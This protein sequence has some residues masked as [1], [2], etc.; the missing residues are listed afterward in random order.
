M[1]VQ[2]TD[3]ALIASNLISGKLEIVWRVSASKAYYSAF[4]RAPK[5]VDICPDNSKLA[6]G[7]HER[8]SNRFWL[9][10]DVKVRSVSYALNTMKKIRHIADYDLDDKF[11]KNTAVKQISDLQVFCEQ[12][13]KI[14]AKFRL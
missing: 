14:D 11:H 1:S 3:F 12:V 13:D 9:H 2:Y 8:L 4:H 5:S 6:M 7:S 10:S